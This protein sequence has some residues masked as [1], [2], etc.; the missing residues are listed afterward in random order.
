MSNSLVVC[1]EFAALATLLELRLEKRELRF[2]VPL[3]TAIQSRGRTLI[4]SSILPIE[5]A[6]TLCYGR[7]GGSVCLCLTRACSRDAGATIE[8]RDE[9]VI[10]LMASLGKELHLKECAI[11]FVSAC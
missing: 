1:R 7:C 4:A 10:S 8:K 3:M 9:E 5:P 6:A 11:Y 2:H